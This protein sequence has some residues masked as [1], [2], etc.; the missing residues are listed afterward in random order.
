MKTTER[1]QIGSSKHRSAP[2]VQL[3]LQI[4]Q[5]LQRIILSW[6]HEHMMSQKP[7]KARH[8]WVGNTETHSI[9]F[10]CQGAESWDSHA[11]PFSV[12][13][14]PP[15]GLYRSFQGLWIDWHPVHHLSA[16]GRF[17]SFVCQR[18]VRESCTYSKISLR[19]QG[20]TGQ[21]MSVLSH[22]W[23]VCHHSTPY[24]KT[25]LQVRFEWFKQKVK[26]I[27][28]HG[29][30]RSDSLGA[31]QCL[32][33]NLCPETMRLHAT[34]APAVRLTIWKS[35]KIGQPRKAAVVPLQ[36]SRC[37]CSLLSFMSFMQ[38]HA[39]TLVPDDDDYLSLQALHF[40]QISK[41]EKVK[42]QS[43]LHEHQSCIAILIKLQVYYIII[44]NI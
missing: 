29:K 1:W 13:I 39:F 4:S 6:M 26:S 9:C 22:S 15:S 12:M 14:M 41:L 7:W 30:S 32:P 43:D 8:L 27:Q 18:I 23:S 42:Q 21:P 37:S 28:K 36:S 38:F 5:A 16:K 19:D 2:L 24:F 44:Y 3:C 40:F 25:L 20:T 10:F 34:F 35:N 31:G 11:H 17:Y 33:S